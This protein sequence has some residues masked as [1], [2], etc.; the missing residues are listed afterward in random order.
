MLKGEKA[1]VL[2]TGLVDRH[3]ERQLRRRRHPRVTTAGNARTP[4]MN[5][6]LLASNTQTCFA[7][8]MYYWGY[9]EQTC[10]GLNVCVTQNSHVEI[11]TLNVKALGGVVFGR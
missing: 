6:R 2:G 11:L 10:Y 1:A 7:I 5:H 3:R 8:P 9:L 4:V